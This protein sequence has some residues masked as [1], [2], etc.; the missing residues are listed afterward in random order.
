MQWITRT[1]AGMALLSLPALAQAQTPPPYV[2]ALKAAQAS[3]S[4]MTKLPAAATLAGDVRTSVN[5]FLGEFNTFAT[6]FPEKGW[7]PKYQAASASLDKTLAAAAAA[8]APAAAPPPAAG[9]PAAA[10]D[11]NAPG[12]CDPTVVEKLKDVRRHLD[13]FE[14]AVPSPLFSA[15]L[16][17]K[18]LDGAGAASGTATLDAAKIAEVKELLKKIRVA[19]GGV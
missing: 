16:V 14:K 2:E 18:I 13:T 11:P 12:V 1:V 7:Q 19:A 3:L 6:A 9:A 5:T 17:E 4:E 10:P 8:P 15:I